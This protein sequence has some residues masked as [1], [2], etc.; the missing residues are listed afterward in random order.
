M[1][2]K[3]FQNKPELKSA[4]ELGLMRESGKVVA[5]ALRIAGR[6][7][8]ALQKHRDVSVRL[9][10]IVKPI[11]LDPLGLD[12]AGGPAGV[13]LALRGRRGARA[14]GLDVGKRAARGQIKHARQRDDQSAI[15]E[16]ESLALEGIN[17]G[18]PLS[19]GPDYWQE[20]LRRLDERLQRPALGERERPT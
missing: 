6:R 4:R 14:R 13:G 15:D 5:A 19:V 2:R 16:L 11:G 9:T 7:P 3:L 12:E 10:A 8:G 18:E 20:Q 1:L 17:S